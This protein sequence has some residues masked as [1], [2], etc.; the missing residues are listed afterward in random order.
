MIHH[1]RNILISHCFH[2]ITIL[3]KTCCGQSVSVCICVL[4]VLGSLEYVLGHSVACHRWSPVKGCYDSLLCVETVFSSRSL[5]LCS[6]KLVLVCSFFKCH[7]FQT[8]PCLFW[9]LISS[10][11]SCGRI[12]C[13]H[14][15]YFNWF[16]FPIRWF[17]DSYI[18]IIKWVTVNSL[19]SG[20]YMSVVWNE[21]MP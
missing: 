11:G 3:L 1:I 5:L 19:R 12:C 14:V 18:L 16:I 8:G 9:K 21:S 20:C 6:S 17:N 13:C 4:C 7:L 10:I 2:K 15:V